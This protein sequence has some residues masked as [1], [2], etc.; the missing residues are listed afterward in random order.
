MIWLLLRLSCEK[1]SMKNKTCMYPGCAITKI[2]ARGLCPRHYYMLWQAG[3]NDTTEREM[4]QLVN[5]FA[6]L[7]ETVAKEDFGT[8]RCMRCQKLMVKR[9]RFHTICDNCK[10]VNARISR[11]ISRIVRA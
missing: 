4:R 6:D 11:R 5:N 10:V 1:F 9:Y 3:Q 7:P 8:R 2:Q